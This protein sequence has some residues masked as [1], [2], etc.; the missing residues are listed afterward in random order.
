MNRELSGDS[1]HRWHNRQSPACATGSATEIMERNTQEWSQLWWCQLHFTYHGTKNISKLPAS[2]I[3]RHSH[4]VA[5]FRRWRTETW[6]SNCSL[7]PFGSSMDPSTIAYFPEGSHR[8]R[9]IS[10]VVWSFHG[11]SNCYNSFWQ[12]DTGLGKSLELHAKIKHYKNKLS[13][14]CP[15]KLLQ[16]AFTK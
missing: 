7:L 15:L 1:P 16:W 8:T 4:T 14:V 9:H 11:E 10:S 5:L 13:V 2:L 6:T 3:Y 12:L